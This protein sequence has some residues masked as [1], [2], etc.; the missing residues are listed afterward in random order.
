MRGEL[1]RVAAIRSVWVLGD[2]LS[3]ANIFLRSCSS[4]GSVTG[5]CS[6]F[7]GWLAYPICSAESLYISRY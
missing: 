7:S 3:K 1:R 6:P 5:C 2:S 4:S